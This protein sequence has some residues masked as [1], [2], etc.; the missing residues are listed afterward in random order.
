MNSAAPT[1]FFRKKIFQVLRTALAGLSGRRSSTSVASGRACHGKYV[2]EVNSRRGEGV[3]LSGV[4]QMDDSPESK[5][6]SP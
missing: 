5:I 1:N 6:P 3:S 2:H 4:A